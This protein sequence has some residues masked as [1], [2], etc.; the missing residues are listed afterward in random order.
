MVEGVADL[1]VALAPLLKGAASEVSPVLSGLASIIGD[2]A[3]SVSLLMG[4]LPEAEGEVQG[5]EIAAI[6]LLVPFTM[7]AGEN[8]LIARTA[9]SVG[10]MR[11]KLEEEL[12]QITLFWDTMRLITETALNDMGAAID[13]TLMTMGQVFSKTWDDIVLSTQ[14][15]REEQLETI[16]GAIDEMYQA[17]LDILEAFWTGLKEKFEEISTWFTE[18]PGKIKAF[19][20]D[21]PSEMETIGKDIFQGLWN[22]LKEK[23]VEV[24]RWVDE[25]V[26]AIKRAFEKALDFGS[27]SKVFEQYGEWIMEGL[28][29]G[30]DSLSPEVDAKVTGLVDPSLMNV[31]SGGFGGRGGGAYYNITIQTGVGDPV[32]IG[33]EIVT[34]VKR[35]ERVSGPV[36]ASA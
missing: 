35:Y 7:L 11:Q 20:D 10:L 33:E 21:L 28:L 2:L 12:P 6:K 14:T 23:W 31:P 4:V 34:A 27:P 9:E 26:Q 15:W 19:F 22:G 3:A 1:A 30:M 29:Q 13:G 8:G 32:R 18:I 24:K 16:R 5:F 17:A 36:F 25:K